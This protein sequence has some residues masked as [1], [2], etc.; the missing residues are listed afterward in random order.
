MALGD[1][2]RRLQERQVEIKKLE[3]SISRLQRKQLDIKLLEQIKAKNVPLS[4]KVML[5]QENHQ[6][7]MTAVQ[8]Y[9]VQ[10]K[11]TGRLERLLNVAKKTLADLNQNY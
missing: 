5:E 9:V 2:H 7:L 6:T 4:F 1:D 11:K 8:K 10:E 3:Q